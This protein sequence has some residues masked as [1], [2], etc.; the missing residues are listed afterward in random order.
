MK[1]KSDWHTRTRTHTIL[2]RRYIQCS[3][4]MGFVDKKIN[5]KIS[6]VLLFQR[7]KERES[8]VLHST[9]IDSSCQRYLLSLLSRLF[10]KWR[11][12]KN[13]RWCCS[14]RKTLQRPSFLHQI[15][16]LSVI[17]GFNVI[18][19]CQSQIQQQHESSQSS[20]LLILII[21]LI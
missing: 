5:R 6:S 21:S 1:K 3:C 7:E 14:R 9:Y 11:P 15:T 19:I 12:D 13:R 10:V 8:T 18:L 4:L 17:T 2:V 16:R 20:T